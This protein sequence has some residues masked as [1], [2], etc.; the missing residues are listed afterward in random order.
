MP[1]TNTFYSIVFPVSHGSFS[2]EFQSCLSVL[3]SF[4]TSTDRR[5]CKLNIFINFDSAKDFRNKKK[6]INSSL[7]SIFTDDCPPTCVLAQ[8]PENSYH[9]AIEAL[10][11][12]TSGRSIRYGRWKKSRYCVLETATCTE[13]WGAG[14]EGDKHSLNTEAGSNGAF[15][16]MLKIL[17]KGKM[18]FD[19]IVRQ[20]NYIG[21]ILK[22]TKTDTS[23]IQ[24]YQIFNEVRHKFYKKYRL[25]TGFPAATGIGCGF[26]SVSIDFNAFAFKSGYYDIPIDNPRQVN[27]FSYEQNKLIGTKKTKHP[28]EFVRGRLISDGNNSV[29]YV[30]GTASVIV[31]E[32]AGTGDVEMQTKTTI[33]NISAL[34]YRKNIKRCCILPI[35]VPEKYRYIRVY[36]KYKDDIPKVKSICQSFFGDIPSIYVQAEICRDS[37]L[38]EI[39]A[40]L[41]C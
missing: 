41:Y 27:P 12:N 15:K 29:L 40:E 28:P 1:L 14:L 34:A 13:L 5:L 31:Q 19:N 26:D 9:I 10:L 38:M 20:W 7:D 25:I 18:N 32:V 4:Q 6:I 11:I 17:Q 36:V 39:E 37:L 24:N 30:S 8:P 16:A 21:N 23:E 2:S 3:K 33:Q 22:I 35:P